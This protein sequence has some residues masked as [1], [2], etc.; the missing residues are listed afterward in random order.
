MPARRFGPGMLFRIY[1]ELLSETFLAYLFHY[2]VFRDKPEC[3]IAGRTLN[4]FA[5]SDRVQLG[6]CFRN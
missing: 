4:K 5:K 1:R 3:P 2:F 6:M